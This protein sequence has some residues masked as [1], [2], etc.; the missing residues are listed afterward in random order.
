LSTQVAARAAICKR[1]FDSVIN[2]ASPSE[3]LDAYFARI[4]NARAASRTSGITLLSVPLRL[5]IRPQPPQAFVR[6]ALPYARRTKSR[7]MLLPVLYLRGV[8]TGDFQESL[9][10]LLGKDA[11][12]LSP[13][14]LT[15]LKLS[16]QDEFERWQ[17]RN[18]SAR[19]YVYIWADGVYLQARMEPD[20]ATGRK[21]PGL[22]GCRNRLSSEQCGFSEISL[23]S[24]SW[25]LRVWQP[26]SL[27]SQG[28]PSSLLLRLSPS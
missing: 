11:P 9:A 19:R 24:C 25:L 28:Q 20:I 5:Y 10:A 13:A 26:W 8:S 15:R 1:R 23:A 27:S 7:D 3:V 2:G 21:H 14:V 22:F 6:A 18:L 17:K 4:A 16:W 12:N